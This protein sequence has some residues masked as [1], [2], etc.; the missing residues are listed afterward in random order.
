M[1]IQVLNTPPN[2]NQALSSMRERKEMY[3]EL[4]IEEDNGGERG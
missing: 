2:L 3:I 4:T 1:Q